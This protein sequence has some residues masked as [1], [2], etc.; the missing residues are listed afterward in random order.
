MPTGYEATPSLILEQVAAE[1]RNGID[2]ASTS[3]VLISDNPDDYP[4][5]ATQ[6]VYVITPNYSGSF[7]AGSWEGGVLQAETSLL[8]TVHQLLELD[9]D[10][11]ADNFF[12]HRKYGVFPLANQVIRVLDQNMLDYSGRALL[13]QPLEPTGYTWNR[14]GSP[15]NIQIGFR[16]VFH[17]DVYFQE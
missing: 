11:R 9:N 4:E 16:C 6:T 17:W 7:D 3:N 2:G 12:N 13:S 1:L 5:S 8:V 14:S 10:A 15:G